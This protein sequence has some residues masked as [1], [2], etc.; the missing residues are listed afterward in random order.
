[1]KSYIDTLY[2]EIKNMKIV[3]GK[4][5]ENINTVHFHEYFETKNEFVII[6]EL[7]DD[8]LLTPFA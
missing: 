5:N 1:M 2:N 3:E 7:C 8:S 4:N 6:M